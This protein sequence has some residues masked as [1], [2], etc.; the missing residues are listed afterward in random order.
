MPRTKRGVDNTPP[1]F[2]FDLHNSIRIA[3]SN[4]MIE[5]LLST[6][7][8]EIHLFEGGSNHTGEGTAF[9]ACQFQFTY[10]QTTTIKRCGKTES[11]S[12]G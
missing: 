5:H 12:S 1:T 3:I 4:Q 8:Y 9:P 6:R 7:F 10:R 11:H 2:L